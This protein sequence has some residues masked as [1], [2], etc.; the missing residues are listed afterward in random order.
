MGYKWGGWNDIDDF[1]G[2]IDQGYGTGTGGGSNTYEDFSI[3]CVVGVSC[4]GFLSRAWHLNEK[5]TLCYKDPDIPRKF[6]EIT[7]TIEGVDL[8]SRQVSLLR[9]G[10]AFINDYHT[11]LFVYETKGG[12]PMV[13]DSSMPGVR[14]RRLTWEYLDSEGYRAIR[15]IN[16]EETSN[17]RGTIENP[18][19]IESDDLPFIHEWNTR[20]VVGM[21]FD[22]YSAA[23]L[24]GHIGPE[25]VYSL[26]MDESAVVSM[27][28]TDI[29]HEG[30]NNDIHLLGSLDRNDEQM[31][32]D[33]I[34]R[35][36]NTI[37]RE[38]D[39]GIYYIII[40]CNNDLP[41]EYT[42]TVDLAGAARE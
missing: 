21:E 19:L 37:T 5:Y 13:M 28:V 9:K 30:I 4:T 17:P 40:D 3:D 41:G 22:R 12:E 26:R 31:A 42:L 35:A 39:G 23:P 16:I 27:T 8:G 32:V 34:E 33:C 15:Y 18:F 11:I 20:D 1:L 14:F 29:K 10:D 6:C 7:Y 36:D 25:V 2:K 38:L 24:I